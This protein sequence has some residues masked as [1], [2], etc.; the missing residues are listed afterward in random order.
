MDISTATSQSFSN[1][2]VVSDVGF[3]IKSMKSEGLAFS[4]TLSWKIKMVELQQ[5]EE[6]YIM[7][8]I[9]TTVPTRGNVKTV[10]IQFR[11]R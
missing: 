1:M 9:T 2:S 5:K 11:Q 6:V 10:L 8:T 7:G 4:F 3:L